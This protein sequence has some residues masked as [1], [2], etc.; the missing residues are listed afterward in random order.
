MIDNFNDLNLNIF[1][2]GLTWLLNESVL[3]H[4]NKYGGLI[5]WLREKSFSSH[6]KGLV[7]LLSYLRTTYSLISQNFCQ[8]QHEWTRRIS[9]WNC[10]C[11][12][13]YP[14]STVINWNSIRVASHRMTLQKVFIVLQYVGIMHKIPILHFRFL[15]IIGIKGPLN[16][17]IKW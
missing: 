16:R 7:V 5:I 1:V 12:N 9:P 11:N 15:N 14:M 6:L 3:Q 2:C 13:P 4:T 10:C 8:F 17:I